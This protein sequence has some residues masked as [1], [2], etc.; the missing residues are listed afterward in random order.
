VACDRDW[1]AECSR[2]LGIAI[3]CLAANCRSAGC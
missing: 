3:D 1:N 2:A